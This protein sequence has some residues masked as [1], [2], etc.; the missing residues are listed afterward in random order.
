MERKFNFLLDTNIVAHL[1][2]LPAHRFERR[3]FN[4]PLHPSWQWK[5]RA[6]DENLHTHKRDRTMDESSSSRSGTF[7][8]RGRS[9]SKSG[10]SKAAIPTP[11]WQEI[12]VENPKKSEKGLICVRSFRV[13]QVH[14]AALEE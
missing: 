1:G 2:F 6:K 13:F 3:R 4:W 10:N 14:K 9:D 12:Q 7:T 11:H 8:S 5:D